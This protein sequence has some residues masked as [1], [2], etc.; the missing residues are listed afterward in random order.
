MA[1]SRQDRLSLARIGAYEPGMTIC[2]DHLKL[3]TSTHFS[4]F[5]NRAFH[6]VREARVWILK[7]IPAAEIDMVRVWIDGRQLLGA[8]LA[9]VTG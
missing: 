6:S 7:F 1:G 4:A 9:A 8:E 2:I 5:S 3:D